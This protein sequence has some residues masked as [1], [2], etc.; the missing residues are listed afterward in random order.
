MGSVVPLALC[1]SIEG[2]ITND[3]RMSREQSYCPSESLLDLND[4]LLELWYLA[5]G[6]I[7]K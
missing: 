3:F 1:G 6:S 5:Q 4:L 7:C 2:S